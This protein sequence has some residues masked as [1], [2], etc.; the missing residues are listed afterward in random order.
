MDARQQIAGEGKE[1]A[2]GLPMPIEPH[3]RPDQMW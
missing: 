3:Q 1:P 2:D